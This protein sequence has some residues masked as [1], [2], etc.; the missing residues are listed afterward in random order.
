MRSW[1]RDHKKKIPAMLEALGKL[2]NAGKLLAAYTEWV[3]LHSC[4]AGPGD[5]SKGR[6]R[7]TCT[8]MHTG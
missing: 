3:A 2:V 1:M 8:R 4:C 6:Q 7:Q 5:C